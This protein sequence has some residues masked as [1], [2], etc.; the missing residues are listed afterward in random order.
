LIHPA[1]SAGLSQIS[2]TASTPARLAAS[3]PRARPSCHT[4]VVDDDAPIPASMEPMFEDAGDIFIE[5][6]SGQRAR[7]ALS[8][9]ELR[10]LIMKVLDGAPRAAN[11]IPIE[12]ARRA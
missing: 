11:I 3:Q 6:M 8:A 7:E 9:G 4:L 12:S 10:T 2:A 5:A 1:R